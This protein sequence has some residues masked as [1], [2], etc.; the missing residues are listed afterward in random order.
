MKYKL[1]IQ[2][3][4]SNNTMF[5]P[6]TGCWFWTGP[7]RKGYARITMPDQRKVSVHRLSYQ[8]YKGEIPIGLLVC[9]HCDN[10]LCINPDHLFLGTYQDNATDMVRKGRSNPRGRKPKIQIHQ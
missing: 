1:P 4:L 2:E 10:R 7:L 5:E 6:N 8:I 3:R 9:H